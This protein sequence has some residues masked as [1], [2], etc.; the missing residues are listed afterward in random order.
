MDVLLKLGIEIDWFDSRW[1]GTKTSQILSSVGFQSKTWILDALLGTDAR[2][3]SRTPLAR[4]IA[5]ANPLSVPKLSGDFPEGLGCDTGAA[6]EPTFRADI[7]CTMVAEKVGFPNPS[8]HLFTGRGA[9]AGAGV[10]LNSETL[11]TDK[12]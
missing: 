1:P 2:G 8:A 9:V 7:T 4:A 10:P 3:V 12:A 11:R 6:L 5:V